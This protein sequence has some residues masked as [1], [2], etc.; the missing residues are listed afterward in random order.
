MKKLFILALLV[1]CAAI[2]QTFT[3]NFGRSVICTG[4]GPYTCAVD[5]LTI[6]ALTAAAALNA[7]TGVKPVK[8]YSTKPLIRIGTGPEPPLPR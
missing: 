4:S 5:G 6:T 3:D 8:V 7:A 1:P 2:A